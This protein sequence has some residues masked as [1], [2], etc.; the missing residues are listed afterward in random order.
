MDGVSKMVY[1]WVQGPITL[2]FRW[3]HLKWLILFYVSR[4]FAWELLNCI[5]FSYYMCAFIRIFLNVIYSV[6]KM[7]LKCFMLYIRYSFVSDV[8]DFLLYLII[9]FIDYSYLLYLLFYLAIY[10]LDYCTTFVYVPASICIYSFDLSIILIFSIS[11]I[12]RLSV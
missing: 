3:F 6:M 12:N 7:T 5:L 8:F 2:T 4:D 10:L 11:K 9:L 1:G